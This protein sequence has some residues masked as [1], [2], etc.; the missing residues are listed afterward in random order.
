MSTLIS[1]VN[2][3]LSVSL[4]GQTSLQS[5]LAISPLDDYS[6]DAFTTGVVSIGGATT[7]N[8][9]TASD[10]D[11]FR[12]SLVAGQTYHFNL[13]GNTLVDPILDLINSSGTI[14]LTNDDVSSTNKN[15]YINYTATSTGD[16]YLSAHA[17]RATTGTYT[18]SVGLDDYG[19]GI[20]TAGVVSIG[21][22]TT[23]VIETAYDVDGFAVSLVAG[24][25]YNFNLIGNTLADTVLDL[26]GTD[27][28]L[29]LSNDDVYGGN[30]SSYISYT[31]ATTGLYYL[32]AK[33]LKET[34]GSY[35]ISAAVDDYSANVAT[36][37]VLTTQS[38]GVVGSVGDNDWFATSLIAGATYQFDLT[39]NTLTDTV[40]N[41]YDANSLLLLTNDDS[42]GTKNSQIIFTAN[43]TAT[44]YLSASAYHT[45]TGSYT[46]GVLSNYVTGTMGDDNLHGDLLSAN[47]NDIINGLAGND[48]LD[49]GVGADTLI[50]G[51]GND[52]YIVDNTGDV[53]VETSTL[54]T[55]ID[56][57]NSSVAYS[58][59]ANVENLTLTGTGSINGI[60]N[61]L[62]NVI[63][64]NAVDNVL[65]GGLGADTLIGGTGN[66]TY[67]VDNTGDV[68]VETSTL[69]TEI[70]TVNSTITYALGANVENLTLTGTD[71]INGIGNSLANVI[72][73]TASANVL[74]GG[75]GA[76]TLI[77][78]AG[79]DTY[80]VDNTGDVV[81]EL[82]TIT[83]EIDTVNSSV[84]Y[85][86]G[87]NVED[88]TLVGVGAIGG[89]GN[90]LANLITGNDAANVL[91]GGLGADTLIG[92]LGNDTYIVDNAGDVVSELSTLATEIDTV[93]S[94]VAYSLGANVENLTLTGLSAINGTGNSLA[95]TLIGNASAN[96]LDGGV[97]ADTLIGGLGNDT[98][99]V[100]N[101]GDVVSEL[102]TIST[103]I[104]SVNS[105]VAYSLGAN[106]EILTLTGLSAINGT[107]NSLANILIGNT[108]ANILD[109]GV[110]A[111]TL[112]G[113]AGNDTYIVDNTGDV[114]LELSTIA[115]E[116]DTVNSSVAYSLGA[117]VENLTLTGLSAINGTGNSLAN[118]LIGNASAN[119]LDGGVGADTLIGG[120]GNDTYIVDNTGDVVSEL[121]TIATE[122]DTVNSS[123][124]YILGANLESLTLTGTGAIN[125][126]GNSLANTLIGNASANILN[127]GTGADTLIGGAGNDTYIVETTGDVVSELSTIVGEIDRVNS[128]I[129]YT[130]G[131]NLENL[132]LTGT[133]AINGTGNSFANTI[134][135]NASA[136]ILNGGT[137]ADTLI[138]GA[139]NDTYIVDNTG[140]VVSE[141]S[142]IATEVDAVNSSISY[143]LGA[144]LE[145]LTLTGTGAINGTGNSLA[146]TIIGNASA[147][148]LNGGTGA[149]TLI[150]GAGN[151]TY[152]VNNTGDVISELSTIATEVDAVNSSISYTLGANIENLTLTGTGVINGTGNSLANIITGN[153]AA[154]ILN[155]LGGA[156]TLIGG[157]GNDTYLVDNTGDVVLELSTVVGEIDR[158]NSSVTYTLGDNVENLLLTGTGTINGTGNTL[159]NAITGNAADNILDGGVG[160][161]LL[162]GGA[163]NDTY[164]VDNA[165]DVVS[166]LSTI[167]SEIDAVYSSV[168]YVL[169][170][171]LENL[172][173]TGT[174]AINGVG[175]S[176]GNV[177]IG[178]ASD[179]VLNGGAG[180]DTLIGGTGNDTYNVDNTG[181]V[182][183]ELSTIVS[184]IDRVNSSVTYTLGDN[185]ENLSLMGTGTINGTG[186]SLANTIVG[187]AAANILD[188]GVGA[189]T[190]IGGAG[191]DTYLV[192]NAGD[193]VS[194][195][196]TIVGE[197]DTV[198]SS[199][200]YVLSA[201]VENLILTGTDSLIGMGNSLANIITG[202]DGVNI[203]VG[204]GGADTLIGGAGN[205]TYLVDNTGD[206]VVESVTNPNEIDTVNSS[207]TYTL[208][209]NVEDL[210]L[211]GIDSI[212]GTGNSG[213]NL[214]MGNN[215]ANVLIGGAGNDTLTGGAGKDTFW[216]TDALD[217]INNVDTITDFVSGN[218]QLEF[219]VSALTGL[220]VIGQW[221]ASDQRFWSSTTGI[222]HNAS[223]RLIYNTSTGELN[224]DSDGTGVLAAV[225][226]EILGVL[227]HPALSAADIIVA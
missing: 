184:E 34:T 134:I 223:D 217:A 116:I 162:I 154:N 62:A 225:T 44:Y 104:D 26:L 18:V 105:S 38:V 101:T 175:N 226:V 218:D 146:N 95:N 63:L 76:D 221:A 40:L 106:V 195:L 194:E 8:I 142:T 102:S 135:G 68:V 75:A 25:T 115:T 57:V 77:G 136:N 168:N 117:N 47:T 42:N 179:N 56:S 110:G 112:I 161:D 167:A 172:T 152:I 78:G 222:A 103:E 54:T 132:T 89:V 20:N 163:G 111:D 60:G 52:T 127:G 202:N 88:L 90:S 190:L 49:G 220:G 22:S 143:T 72:I 131:A 212:N 19:S 153:A 206:V 97:G 29:L 6:A 46:L 93:N 138:G 1:T 65:D 211:A 94:S 176:L 185:V 155:G 147:N 183:S 139:G 122:V 170:A 186:N 166:E 159:G 193:V 79:N 107:G 99:I 64:G 198:I 73:G 59:G 125:G 118:T 39:G 30:L 80:I 45:L 21:G 181:D 41:L 191:N 219:S 98:Y 53:V 201:N 67:L 100:D 141:L 27:G 81:S 178:N 158:V 96:V 74:D 145:K 61:S 11:W 177:L 171:N 13:T 199:V 169:G 48:T 133:G 51:T 203:L 149:D 215:G 109:G 123:I 137:G 69:V 150:G 7:G 189:D 91:D 119:I 164:I 85:T 9:E 165:G 82:S 148:I 108:S 32:N 213:A 3:P 83:T 24:T 174:G 36:T 37:G 31:A 114:V 187:N 86:L 129:S 227:T 204:G 188:G 16:Y 58:L 10:V 144:N 192:D 124:S 120:A 128:S 92:G 207:V 160:A 224:Y 173:L 151:D 156:D 196:S 113:G 43:N 50:G 15:S 197:I 84:T 5:L 126:T 12:V 205:D 33:G 66:D 157:A 209:A 2:S 130:L 180:A 35:S 70:D 140:D 200:S 28:T 14:L 4:F 17:I 214:I 55:E 210:T 216:F 71:S 87:T 182:V 121:S 23:G 208:S